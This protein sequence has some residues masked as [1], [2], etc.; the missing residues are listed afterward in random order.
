M[1]LYLL[2]LIIL[3]PSTGAFF[4][5]SAKTDKN[6]SLGNIYNVSIWTM[7][8]NTILILYVFSL[9]DTS[10]QGIEIVE[11]Y[12]WLTSPKIDILLGVDV[13]SMLLLLSTNISFLIAEIFIYK[14][15]ERS[16]TLIASE[17]LFVSLLN[18]YFIAADIIS[19]YIFFAAVS[20]PLIILISTYAS[21]SKKNI[22][23]RFSLYNIIGVLLLMVAT[24]MIFNHKENNIPLNMAGNVNIVGSLEYF[25]WLSIFLAFIS[26]IPV[27]PFHYWIS[28]ISS[29]IK[30]PLVFIVS[31][32]IPLMGL[33]GF[34]RFW[35]NTVPKTISVYAPVFEVVCVV[36]MVFIAL[37][38][39]SN[40]DMRYKLFAYSTVYYLLFLIGIF[41][42]TNTLRQNIGYSLFSYT[43]IITVLSFLISHVEEQKKKLDIYSSAGLLC[44]MPKVS[45]SLSL[46]ILAGIGLP[47]TP[48]FW[49]NFIIISEIFNY[50]LMLGVFVML[51]LMIIGV[52]FLEELY[53][54]KDKTYATFSNVLISDMPSYQFVMC[55]AC[56]IVLFLSFFKPLWFVF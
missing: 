35:P 28:A 19:F 29:G 13:F 34:T 48:L 8:L 23:V 11:K 46:F 6:Y 40:K 49:N 52:S 7:L 38:S 18:G 20:I 37:I 2:L 15:S 45:K 33:Y 1:S 30:N 56:M 54:Q 21:I 16:K 24:I 31:N 27:W 51:S 26:R 5:L 47:I 22:L 43:I 39:L 9:M 50:N 53:K 41:M 44:Y 42:P 55:L 12:T 14:K 17:L 32:L 25:V 36:T 4:T 10:K 3:I